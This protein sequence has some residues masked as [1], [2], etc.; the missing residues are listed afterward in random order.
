MTEK[1][2]TARFE[3]RPNLESNLQP[4]A[5]LLA[6]FL[7]AYLLFETLHSYFSESIF[8]SEIA[9][10]SGEDEQRD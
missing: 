10:L 4:V 3:C 8:D 1:S 9:K 2:D 6:I 7:Y 5:F